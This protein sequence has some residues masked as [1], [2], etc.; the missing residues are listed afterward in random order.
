MTP[1][2][3]ISVCAA[4]REALGAL[5]SRRERPRELPPPPPPR[6][7]FTSASIKASGGRE[8]AINRCEESLPIYFQISHLR[9]RHL[10]ARREPIARSPFMHGASTAEEEEGADRS[11]GDERERGERV[12]RA[13]PR[14]AGAAAV[15]DSGAAAL[16]VGSARGDAWQAR[17]GGGV[18]DVGFGFLCLLW[19]AIRRVSV[20]PTALGTPERRHQ[21]D[22]VVHLFFEERERRN[23]KK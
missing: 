4:A 15:G 20:L 8:R 12:E 10:A 7:S 3:A 16:S 17:H 2:D 23:I 9:L 1:Y 13:L 18:P 21:P 6:P 22:L 5:P 11:S 19:V 14:V